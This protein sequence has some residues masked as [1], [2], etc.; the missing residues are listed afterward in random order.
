MMMCFEPE[1]T[2]HGFRYAEVT[3]YP[4]ILTDM[5]I[6]SVSRYSNI[7]LRGDFRCGSPMLNAINDICVK[8]ELANIHSILTDCP[9]RD[10][11]M[12]WM[13]DATSASRKRRIISKPVGS[14][15]KLQLI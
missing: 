3:G 7:G 13:N 1:F 12:G 9:Q 8:T 10:E 11:R 4:D 5:D 2:Y 14:G 6:I 15:R